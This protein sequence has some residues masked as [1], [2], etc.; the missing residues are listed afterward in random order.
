MHYLGQNV[1]LVN[2]RDVQDIVNADLMMT[3]FVT[4]IREGYGILLNNMVES[5]QVPLL[6]SGSFEI[7]EIKNASSKIQYLHNPTEFIDYLTSES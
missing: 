1:P 7:E 4:P 3:M 5:F 6:I 2:I